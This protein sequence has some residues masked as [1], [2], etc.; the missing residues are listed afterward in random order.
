MRTR[1]QILNEVLEIHREIS[2]MK[3]RINELYIEARNIED[4]DDDEEGR[5]SYLECIKSYT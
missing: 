2:D 3:Q 4:P 1:E 5:H